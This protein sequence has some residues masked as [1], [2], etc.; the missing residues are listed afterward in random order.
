MFH[1]S[2]FRF[3]VWNRFLL[4]VVSSLLLGSSGVVVVLSTN[5][6]SNV[7]YPNR[8]RWEPTSASGSNWSHGWFDFVYGTS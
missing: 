4:L 3:R 7:V 8:W 6:V 1:V 2:S 5:Q